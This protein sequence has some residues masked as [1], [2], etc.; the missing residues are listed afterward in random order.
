MFSFS[1]FANTSKPFAIKDIKIALT[2]IV[3]LTA[4]LDQAEEKVREKE[5]Q[6]GQ[7]EDEK[8]EYKRKLDQ[9][10]QLGPLDQL[11]QLDQLRSIICA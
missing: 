4:S 10:I 1:R 9:F 11:D 2:E 7:V 6:I 8:N 5:I 3:E